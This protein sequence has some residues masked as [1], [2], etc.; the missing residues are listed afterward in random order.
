MFRVS[1]RVALQPIRVVLCLLLQVAGPSR[2]FSAD[3]PLHGGLH[4][5]N[6]NWP[7]VLC[8]ILVELAVDDNMVLYKNLACLRLAL[9]VPLLAECLPLVFGKGCRCQRA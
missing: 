2:Y 6:G 1:R 7:S 5:T 3:E 8:R 9:F 4:V